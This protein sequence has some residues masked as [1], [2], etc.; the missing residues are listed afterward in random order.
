MQLKDG[1]IGK[2]YEY[3]CPL[4]DGSF[5]FQLKALSDTKDKCTLQM[6]SG[7]SS[8]WPTDIEVTEFDSV[9]NK[10]QKSLVV[11]KLPF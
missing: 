11:D 5:I 2:W 6:E 3:K 4:F 8:R 9:V 10:Q 7:A 1:T